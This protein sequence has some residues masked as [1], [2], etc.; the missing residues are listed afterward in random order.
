MNQAKY[1]IF[2]QTIQFVMEEKAPEDMCAMSP[3]KL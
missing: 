1:N 2:N 3:R